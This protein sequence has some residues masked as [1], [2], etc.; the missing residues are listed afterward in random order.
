MNKYI[1]TLFACL[2]SATNS[3][4]ADEEALRK[5]SDKYL[6]CINQIS[7]GMDIHKIHAQDIISPNC[8]KIL[9]GQLYTQTREE[10][11]MDL[12]TAYK[13]Q[14][15]WELYPEDIIIAPS[16]HA[17]VLRLFIDMETS[18]SY[19]AIVILRFDSNYLVTEI[20]E[21]LSPVNGAYDF[22]LANT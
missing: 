17:V 15:A 16:Y 3:L 5:A 9:N 18:A 11:L 12:R 22:K 2:F 21:V 10:F 1:F 13:N 20:N 4:Q 7:H 6:N 8:K 14:G 19:T